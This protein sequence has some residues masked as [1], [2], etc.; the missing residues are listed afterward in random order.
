MVDS[1]T[2]ENLHVG[3]D[4]YSA[5]T[6]WQRRNKSNTSTLQRYPPKYHWK[7]YEKRVSTIINIAGDYIV[8]I[9]GGI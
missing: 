8:V 2:T 6:V 7:E 9:R 4:Y 5:P 1:N 3:G